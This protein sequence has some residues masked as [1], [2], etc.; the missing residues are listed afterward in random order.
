MHMQKRLAASK[1]L[2]GT[3]PNSQKIPNFPIA[4][5]VGVMGEKDQGSKFSDP[6]NDILG[7]LMA[8]PAQRPDFL[9]PWVMRMAL[10]TFGA[11]HDTINVALAASVF[12]IA[13]NPATL[14]RVRAELA[15][16][17]PNPR[18]SEAAKLPY[19]QACIKE[20][21]RLFP[22]IANSMSRVVPAGGVKL[23]GFYLPAGTIVG[24]VP[25]ALHTDTSIFGP[26]AGEFNPDRWFGQTQGLDKK[27][28]IF[29][30][31]SRSCPGQYLAMFIMVKTLVAIF[32]GFDVQLKSEKEV[33][34]V[35]YFSAHLEDCR[36]S[37]AIRG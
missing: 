36:A 5:A 20:S 24:V 35:S 34:H 10:T 13:R 4:K 8:L 27:L 19:L 3:S 14:A 1:V 6:N 26:D 25:T 12:C 18:Y 32:S 7:D 16:L 37:F 2:A 23:S 15:T 9:Q 17:G 33:K 21:I 29:G 22:A 11:A 31:S 30:G 28:L